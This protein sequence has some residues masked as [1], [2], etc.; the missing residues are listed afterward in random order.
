[1]G[2]RVHICACMRLRL[3]L[4][5]WVYV[6]IYVHACMRLRFY[7]QY[8]ADHEGSRTARGTSRGAAPR[9]TI[10]LGGGSDRRRGGADKTPS[11]P[12]SK[13]SMVCF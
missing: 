2:V 5:V 11:L 9:G 1:M 10:D 6:C 12:A 4:H 8:A 13:H 3:R 7:V